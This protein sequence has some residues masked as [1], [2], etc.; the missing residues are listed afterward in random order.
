MKR[1]I[2]E[3]KDIWRERYMK[4]K[5]YEEKDIWRE[6]DRLRKRIGRERGSQKNRETS[7]ERENTER[8]Q[9]WIKILKRSV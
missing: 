1:N 9:E 8:E 6:R 5:I 7:N 2:Y 4:R 3:E